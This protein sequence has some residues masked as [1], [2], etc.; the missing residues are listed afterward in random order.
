ML[1]LVAKSSWTEV[2]YPG[3]SMSALGHKPT[4]ALQNAMSALGPIA[5]TKA[6]IA[7]C[8]VRFTPKADVSGALAC[9]CYGPKADI[10]PCVRGP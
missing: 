3:A 4:F 10:A 7:P 5:T 8:H 9:V 2:Q 6:D 1:R